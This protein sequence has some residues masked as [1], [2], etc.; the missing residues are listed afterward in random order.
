MILW[1]D[2]MLV[3]IVLLA[4]LDVVAGRLVKAVRRGW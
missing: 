4:A 3:P 2:L 1:T